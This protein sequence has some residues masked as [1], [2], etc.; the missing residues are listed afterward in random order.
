MTV[1][2]IG[3]GLIGG[4]FAKAATGAG[5]DTL[6]QN[7]TR[8][9]SIHAISEG[10]AKGIIETPEDLARCEIVVVCLP[11]LLCAPWIA[12][13][14]KYFAKGAIVCDAAGVKGVVAK[15]LHR[16]A[17]DS[18]W[19]FI[20]AHPMAG[21]EHGGYG[22][23]T[24]TLYK[25]ASAVFTPWASS[26]RGPLDKLEAFFRSLGFARIVYTTPERHDEVIAFTSQLPHAISYSYAAD[27]LAGE[28]DGFTGGSFQDMTRI[29][30]SD[31]RMWAQ[32]FAANREHFLAAAG[33]FR[34]RFNALYSAV[35]SGGEDD[36]AKAL[37]L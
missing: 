15:E 33:R 28:A 18:D 23:A 10:V 30:A 7:R 2:I 14:A 4:S 17:L 24:A 19:T 12:E 9:V 32:L 37:L 1:G 20:G 6:V 27:P 16:F 21:K 5:Y 25:G 35:E 36:I 22:H 34:D 29:S 13:H 8:A 11:P 3:L 26:G 31:G